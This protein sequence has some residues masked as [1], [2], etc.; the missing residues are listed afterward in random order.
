MHDTYLGYTRY[1]DNIGKR[2]WIG[3][4]GL[5][6]SSVVYAT[7][8][9]TARL[10]YERNNYGEVLLTIAHPLHCPLHNLIRP[11]NHHLIEY[12]KPIANKYQIPNPPL[13]PLYTTTPPPRHSNN[14]TALCPLSSQTPTAATKS[15]AAILSCLIEAS[16]RL[17]PGGRT[18]CD[19][20]MGR[21]PMPPEHASSAVWPAGRPTQN[22]FFFGV[23][24]RPTPPA[25]CPEGIGRSCLVGDCPVVDLYFLRN[26]GI[27]C[28][29]GRA[30]PPVSRRNGVRRL[31][32]RAE[33]SPQPLGW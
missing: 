29:G 1:S 10:S 4:G 7:R 17:P 18:E 27:V 3:S 28:Q 30:L 14:R 23:A 13:Q 5:G 8:F 2:S 9:L 26:V 20:V 15:L 6:L 22:I 31:W 25:L 24:G 33:S 11:S 32:L 19:F 16:P 21:R 12:S